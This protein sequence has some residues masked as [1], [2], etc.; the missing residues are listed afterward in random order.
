MTISS[1]NV[2][3]MK[4]SLYGGP[5]KYILIGN[6]CQLISELYFCLINSVAIF[7]Q[8]YLFILPFH[9]IIL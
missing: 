7:F 4:N 3:A 1:H 2:K 8:Y 6:P 9:Y 5:P